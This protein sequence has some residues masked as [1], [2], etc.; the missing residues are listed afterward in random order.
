LRC[1]LGGVF[2]ERFF[3]EAFGVHWGWYVKEVFNLVEKLYVILVYEDCG[4]VGTGWDF[5]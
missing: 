1:F 2:S 4:I 5:Q 3:S